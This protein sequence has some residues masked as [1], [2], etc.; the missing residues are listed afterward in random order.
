MKAHSKKLSFETKINL[1]LLAIGLILIIWIVS[2]CEG[3]RKDYISTD[4]MEEKHAS[5]MKY[6]EKES[7]EKRLMTIIAQELHIPQ[8]NFKITSIN[9]FENFTIN[10]FSY[11]LEEDIYEGI[12]QISSDGEVLFKV[13]DKINKNEPFTLR[14]VTFKKEELWNFIVIYG[15]INTPIIESININFYDN[16]M[17]NMVLGD[18]KNYIYIY[19]NHKLPIVRVEGLDKDLNIFYQWDKIYYDSL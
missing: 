4:N 3:V 2:F 16:T 19:E 1:C 13:V 17:V 12:C 9:S 18:K 11:G 10:T 7:L 14:E 8:E 5:M 15:I 6:E